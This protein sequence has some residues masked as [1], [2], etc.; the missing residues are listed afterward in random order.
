[1]KRPVTVLLL[2]G[3]VV[4]LGLFPAYASDRSA[5]AAVSPATTS[6]PAPD[7]KV[8]NGYDLKPQAILDMQEMQKKYAGLAGAIPQDKYTWRPGEGVRSVSEVF[9][10]VTQANYYIL[11]MMGVPAPPGMDAKDF[12]KST[13]DK[14]KIIS[15][16]N[17]SFAFAEAQVQNMTNADLAKPLPKLGPDANQGDVVFLLVTH[18]HEHLGQSIAYARINGVVP[19]WTAAA[20]AAAAKK[21]QKPQD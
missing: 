13:T 20:N 8:T 14:A 15:Q 10:H 3:L 18:M 2:L 19:P 17:E 1:M 16:L 7:E 12:E 4:A 21:A 9:L 11:S 6:G 5:P